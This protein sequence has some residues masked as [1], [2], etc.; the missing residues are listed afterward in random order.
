M[1]AV[2]VAALVVTPQFLNK[3]RTTDMRRHV[4]DATAGSAAVADPAVAPTSVTPCPDRPVPLPSGGRGEVPI[5][6][7][8]TS[9]RLCAA[10]IPGVDSD[11]VDAPG[12][13]LTTGTATFFRTLS[14]LPPAEVQP[15]DAVRV[16]ARPYVYL[17]GFSDGSVERVYVANSCDDVRV[18][19]VRLP[20]DVVLRTYEHAL[21]EQ[22]SRAGTA[23]DR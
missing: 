9:I 23:G 14:A 6:A 19:G 2:A 12:D 4:A 8:A 11:S 10:A 17:V 22:R 5:R 21:E 16:A 3:S 20:S 13:A 7:E 18:S 1:V 15:C